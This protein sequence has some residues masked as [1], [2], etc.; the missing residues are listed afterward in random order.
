MDGK[1]QDFHKVTMTIEPSPKIE[2]K[3]KEISSQLQPQKE[4]KVT[5]EVP[6]E[7]LNELLFKLCKA[8]VVNTTDEKI[9]VQSENSEQVYVIS[10]INLQKDICKTLDSE[11]E[12]FQPVRNTFRGEN[13]RFTEMDKQFLR[14]ILQDSKPQQNIEPAKVA[15]T[16]ENSTQKSDQLQM[17]NDAAKPSK[18]FNFSNLEDMGDMMDD[19]LDEPDEPDSDWGSSQQSEDE[20]EETKIGRKHLIYF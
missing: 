13:S 5:K 10:K 1:K 4:L 8:K 9:Y 16:E 3:N 19:D 18:A 17:Q 7:N 6:V 12:Q 14:N 2:T 15:K 20:K 11:I